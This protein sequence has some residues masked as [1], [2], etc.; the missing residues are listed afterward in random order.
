MHY[1]AFIFKFGK[2]ESFTS[3]IKVLNVSITTNF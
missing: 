3:K 1:Y 2:N